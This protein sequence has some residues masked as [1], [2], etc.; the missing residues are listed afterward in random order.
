MTHRRNIIL[1][2]LVANILVT[3]LFWWRGSSALFADGSLDG[4]L[5]ALGRL[6][7]LCLQIG[8]LVQ[9]ILISRLPFVE[10]AYGFDRLNR[11]HRTLGYVLVA[12]V[13]LH[14]VML[15]VGYAMASGV[16]L[17]AQFLDFLSTWDE[18]ASAVGGLTLL[19][20]GGIVSAPKIKKFM[21][22]GTWHLGHL[23]MYLAVWLVFEHQFNSEDVS[24]GPAYY[25]WYALNYSVFGILIIHRFLRPLIISLRHRFYIEKIVAESA[26]VTSVY[27][28]GRAMDR[29]SFKSGQFIH[30]CFRAPGFREPHPFS[31]SMAPDGKHLRLSIKSSGDFTS[32]IK[33]LKHGTEALLEGPF[34]RFTEDAAVKS[35]YL[36]I[37]GGIGITPIRSMVE[38]LSERGADFKLIHGIKTPA[39]ATFLEEFLG[40]GVVPNYIYS[41]NAPV[42]CRA[43]FVDAKS[44]QDLAPD[45]RER[46]IYV[47][48]PP[49]MTDKIVNV[50]KTMAVP[51]SQIHF[52]RFSY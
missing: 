45:Y 15:V 33:D 13:I 5:I 46:D 34:G 22:Y 43:G 24:A 49:I 50:L 44:I 17:T 2:I 41:E 19:I 1:G 29:F 40:M 30:V 32:R 23:L 37:A 39:D 14:P 11:V 26:D 51:L 48:G 35:K 42:G 47:C 9:L 16:S 12:S 6:F 28:T 10:R 18:V 7:G 36:F 52:E 21:E 4:W 3:A 38:S 31:L 25:Y 8:L 27:L 20:I